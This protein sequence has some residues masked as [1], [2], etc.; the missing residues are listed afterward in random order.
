MVSETALAAMLEAN[1]ASWV[2]ALGIVIEE[3]HLDGVSLS[4]AATPAV[5][6]AGGTLCGQ[7]TMALADTAMALAIARVTGGFPAMTTI[8][9][10]TSF[11]RPVRGQR[12]FARARVLRLG[13]TLAYGEIVLHEGEE[14]RPVAH[15]TSSYM[16]L[17]AATPSESGTAAGGE[18]PRER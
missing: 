12:L 17:A 9:Q 14:A 15:A 13:R 8:T 16:L 10:T 3:L 5:A 11:L 6:R 2:R 7:A 18:R 1:F 4:I